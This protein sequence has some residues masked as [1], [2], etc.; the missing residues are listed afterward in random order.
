MQPGANQSVDVGD[1]FVN[2]GN[3]DSGAELA[4]ATV[5]WGMAS[6]DAPADVS[7][8]DTAPVIAVPEPSSIALVVMGLLGGIGMI[9]RRR[10]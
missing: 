9:R 3:G 7:L 8:I 2:G 10:S 4:G 6:Y 5:L 1:L